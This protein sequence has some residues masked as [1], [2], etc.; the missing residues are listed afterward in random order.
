MITGQLHAMRH[1][2]A[3]TTAVC[4]V[5]LLPT[6]AG[7]QCTTIGIK[8]GLNVSTLSVDDPSNPSLELDNTMG[9]LAGA[10][11]QCASAGW[12]A[13]QGEVDY[14]QNGAKAQ[15]E[16][17]ASELS[18]NYLRVPVLVMARLGSG[19]RT[20]TPILYFGPQV[21]FETRCQVTTQEN[22]AS[23]SFDCD[24]PELDAPL[25]TNL[26]EFGLVFGGGLDILLGGLKM[27]L[28]ARYN[29]GL[30]NLNGG[31]DASVVSVKNRGWSFTVG[32]GK[33]FG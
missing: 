5:V 18:L 31:T 32:L 28:D 15:G 20:A 22:G 21:A 2:T 12:F 16:D 4:L 25:E 11:I 6:G 14:S 17:P 27:Q 19:K 30:T 10:F 1:L 13:L 3:L 24:S 26:V 33:P 7:A 8:G 23:E 9:F 29:L